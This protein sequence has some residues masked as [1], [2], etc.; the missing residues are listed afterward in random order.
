M[1]KDNITIYE[2][3][4]R[5][6]GVGKALE[7]KLRGLGISRIKDLLFHFPRR[8]E[9]RTKINLINSTDNTIASLIEGE[10]KSSSVVFARRRTLMLRVSDVSGDVMVRFFYFNKSQQKSFRE[11][12]K[13]RLFGQIRQ[14]RYAKEMVH[15]ECRTID[16]GN[17]PPLEKTLTAIYPTTDGLSQIRLRRLV[18]QALLLSENVDL[19][20]EEELLPKKLRQSLDLPNLHEAIRIIHH[21]PKG[22]ELCFTSTRS[23]PAQKRLIFEE[24]LAH[25]ISLKEKRL[26]RSKHTAPTC[27]ELKKHTLLKNRIGFSLTKGQSD[28]ISDISND[29]GSGVPM[30]RLLQGDVGSGK[31]A[32]AAMAASI[33]IEEGYKVVIMAPT[34]LLVDQ[35]YKTFSAWFPDLEV[36]LLTGKLG[37]RE[38]NLVKRKIADECPSIVIGTHAVFQKDV[39]YTKLGLI[40]VDEQHRFGVG[41]RLA[42]N[43]KGDSRGLKAHQLIMTATPIPRTLAMAA[44][45]DLD[46]STIKDLPPGRSPV[47]TA[48]I[49][50]ERRKEVIARIS[51][52][53]DDG[54]QVYWVCP[55]IEE[56]DKI[57]TES[58]IKTASLLA[59]EIKSTKVGLIHG[60]MKEIDKEKIMSNFMNG[61][62]NLLVATTVIEVGVD[63]PNASLMII[64]NAERLG[65]AQLHQL[66]GRVGRGEKQSSCLLLYKTPLSEMA[67]KRL[68][69]IRTSNNGFEIAE[70]D[71]ELRGPGELLG[72]RQAGIAQF[73]I[74]D[75]TLDSALIELVEKTAESLLLEQP[76]VA[77]KIQERWLADRRG[78]R[79]V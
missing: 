3:V 44:Y 60:R 11:G 26:N 29:L 43:Q 45:A 61:H 1:L 63:V 79:Y 8:Y 33:L 9:N 42:L 70:R 66:R 14:G 13:V 55:L 41:Q 56:S 69:A 40:I 2:S 68:R 4:D 27:G 30:L 36:I 59:E 24:L 38:R 65:L 25:Q 74:A 48:V 76:A 22:T 72:T 58:A 28:A 37:E 6:Y 62:I 52:A 51:S 71:M 57:D 34:E 50:E 39:V 35:H 23:H 53:V 16:P 17:P 47:T 67:E 46:I 75:L 18:Q 32:V 19:S 77:K 20:H 12:V 54:T 78:Y 10:I 21:P 64:E 49:P 7:N 5:L 73:K 31:T 15:P